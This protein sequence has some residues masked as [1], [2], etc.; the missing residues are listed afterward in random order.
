MATMRTLSR[1]HE[2]TASGGNLVSCFFPT[3]LEGV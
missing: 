1:T 2:G 3:L